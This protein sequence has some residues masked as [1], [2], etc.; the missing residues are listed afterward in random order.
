M[1][2]GSTCDYVQ[3]FVCHRSCG[4]GYGYL[5]DIETGSLYILAET[6]TKERRGNGKDEWTSRRRVNAQVEKVVL[7]PRCR[8]RGKYRGA[9]SAVAGTILP[10]RS[11]DLGPATFVDVWP[12]RVILGIGPVF[13]AVTLLTPVRLHQT[14]AR[15]PK[16]GGQAGR[17]ASSSRVGGRSGRS[18]AGGGSAG[19]EAGIG[20]GEEGGSIG[21][22]GLFGSILGARLAL[23]V[24]ICTYVSLG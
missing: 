16:A 6:D 22:L 1:Y 17:G 21:D 10:G 12:G 13:V 15:R 23:R 18:R 5:H 24:S 19:S 9:E 3:W 14:E 11:R 4:S 20:V 2:K 7:M 8:E